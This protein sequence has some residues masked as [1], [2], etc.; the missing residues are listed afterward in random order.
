MPSDASQLQREIRQHR[1]FASPS[2][3]ALLGLLRTA[4]VVRARI[5]EIV[6]PHGVTPQQYNVLRILRGAAPEGLPTLDI[7]ERMLERAPGITRLL[8]RLETKGL[9]CRQRSRTDRRQVFCT[10]TPAGLELLKALDRPVQAIDVDFAAKLSAAQ[11]RQLIRL[12][13]ALREPPSVVV[14]ERPRSN[15]S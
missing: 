14:A 12:M 11:Q 4:D 13:D 6:E 5:A 3:E 1:P 2:Q 9:A 10:I 7:V 15:R 8:D